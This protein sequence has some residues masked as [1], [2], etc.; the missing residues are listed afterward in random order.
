M[1]AATLDTVYQDRLLDLAD[2]I[3]REGCIVANP[4]AEAT[5]VSRACGSRVTVQVAF[6][7]DTV[8][9]YG[10]RVD[11]C[12]LGSAAASVVGAAVIGASV[13]EIRAAGRALEAMLTREGPAPTGRFADLAALAPATAFP[14]RHAS[15]LLTFRALEKTFKA[16]GL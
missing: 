16:V 7:G 14:N 2:P 10:Q 9:D 11:A 6:A 1:T 5:A 3:I 15:I 13:E 12:A 8:S 4:D